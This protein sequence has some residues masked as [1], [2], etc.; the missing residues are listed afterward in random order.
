M[1]ELARERRL[2]QELLA[3]DRAELAVAE[4]LRLDRLQRHFLAGEAVFREIDRPARAL[5]EELLDL[6]SPDLEAEGRASGI[7]VARS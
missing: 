4:N 5:A 1:P 2:V 3:V 7:H 6:V